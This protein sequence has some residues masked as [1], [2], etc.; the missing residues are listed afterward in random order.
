[1][2][3]AVTKGLQGSIVSGGKTAAAG[4]PEARQSAVEA[5]D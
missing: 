1:M 2:N 5:D 4:N 3:R